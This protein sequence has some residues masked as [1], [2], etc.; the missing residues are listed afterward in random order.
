[1]IIYLVLDSMGLYL[2]FDCPGMSLDFVN[3]LSRLTS[4]SRAKSDQ[5]FISAALILP[6]MSPI[7]ILVVELSGWTNS[8]SC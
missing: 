1:M 4:I 6:R 5:N 2:F 8:Y 7:L 3:V